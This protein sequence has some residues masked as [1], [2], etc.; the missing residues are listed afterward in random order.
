VDI[1]V[2][3]V[4]ELYNPIINLIETRLENFIIFKK[5]QYICLKCRTKRWKCRK[6]PFD[7][8]RDDEV[9][10]SGREDFTIT[11]LPDIIDNLYCWESSEKIL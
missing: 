10:M 8:F 3:T 11:T 5:R 6:L 2:F 9:I 1:A 4:I 7:E